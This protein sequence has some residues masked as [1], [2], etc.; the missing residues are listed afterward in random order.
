MSAIKLWILYIGVIGTG[1]ASFLIM[2]FLAESPEQVIVGEWTEQAWEYERVNKA[3]G[4]S[5]PTKEI[6]DEVKHL[7]GQNLIIHQAETWQ[8]LPN[9]KLKL[10]GDKANKTASWNIKGRGHILTLQYQNTN[11]ENYNISEL[12]D[13][14]LVINFDADIEV[15]GVAKLIFKKTNKK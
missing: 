2:I 14:S 9:G 7:I 10:L 3:N 6:T 4:D 12:T 8:F 13:T 5:V 11:F 15:R 1:V